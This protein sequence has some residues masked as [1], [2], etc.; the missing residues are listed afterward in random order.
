MVIKSRRKRWADV[1]VYAYEVVFIKRRYYMWKDNIKV[2]LGK[3]GHKY[4]LNS[5]GPRLSQEGYSMQFST[6]SLPLL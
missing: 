2:N 1:Y 4:S 6:S 5:D 3:S